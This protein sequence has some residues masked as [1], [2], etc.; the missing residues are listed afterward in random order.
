MDTGLLPVTAPNWDRSEYHVQYHLIDL[1]GAIRFQGG[2]APKGQLG[3]A[4]WMT[5]QMQ[6]LEELSDNEPADMKALG[7]S[8]QT[9]VREV[10][11]SWPHSIDRRA[12]ILTCS[13]SKMPEMD[14]L[15]PFLEAMTASCPAARPTAHEALAGLDK[16]S[17]ELPPEKIFERFSTA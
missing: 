6:E 16:I 9:I 17:A 3:A 8:L 14:F 2:D 10:R 4:G 12:S 11:L 5:E 1:S 13:L 15:S 7:S